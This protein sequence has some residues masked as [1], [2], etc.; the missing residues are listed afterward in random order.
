[1]AF[2]GDDTGLSGDVFEWA[3]L[4]AVNNDD[5]G[6][7]NLIAD[8]LGLAGESVDRPQARAERRAMIE[9]AERDAV[10]LAQWA[11]EWLEHLGEKGGA[12]VSI[13][14][15]RS[16]LRGARAADAWR[17]APHVGERI[18]TERNSEFRG[19]EKRSVR[20]RAGGWLRESNSVFSRG[21]SSAPQHH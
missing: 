21:P 14:T 6:V 7:T 20:V 17:G 15:H 11:E 19:P 3:L 18:E 16:V 8:A 1:M 2:R 10:T 13:V 5:P 9:Q 12:E 4:L